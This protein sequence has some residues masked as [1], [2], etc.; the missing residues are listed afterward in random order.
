MS[1]LLIQDLLALGQLINLNSKSLSL[2]SI[3]D[4]R[5]AMLKEVKKDKAGFIKAAMKELVS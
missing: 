2:I 1:N 3:P 5:K 4:D